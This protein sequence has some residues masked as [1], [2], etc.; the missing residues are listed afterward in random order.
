M[1][2][3]TA[4]A[5]AH[6][7]IQWCV[8]HWVGPYLRLL[9]FPVQSGPSQHVSVTCLFLLTPLPRPEDAN[10]S[11]GSELRKHAIHWLDD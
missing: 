2:R 8:L 5:R 6:L 7:L 3:R 10:F 4:Q 11:D 1:F 9:A